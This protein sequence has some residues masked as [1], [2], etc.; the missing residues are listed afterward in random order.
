MPYC[1]IRLMEEH[2]FFDIAGEP[3]TSAP[4]ASNSYRLSP[5]S[6]PCPNRKGSRRFLSETRHKV[7]HFF[8]VLGNFG[9]VFVSFSDTPARSNHRGQSEKMAN[10]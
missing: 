5:H 1:G 10:A 6:P 3:A 7:Y 9:K 4:I 2:L 8:T